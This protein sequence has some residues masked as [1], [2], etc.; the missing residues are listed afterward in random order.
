MLG[1]LNKKYLNLYK[2]FNLY[3]KHE[4]IIDEY[5]EY[6]NNIY[7]D[8]DNKVYIYVINNNIF[9]YNKRPLSY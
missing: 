8:I 6:V 1:G 5:I 4:Y 9:I 3:N 7:C 2:Y